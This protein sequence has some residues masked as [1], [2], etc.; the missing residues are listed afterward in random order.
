[1]KSSLLIALIV[2]LGAAYAWSTE[3]ATVNGRPVTDKDMVTALSNLN[4]GQR[5]NV[6]RDMASKR[7]VLSSVIDQEV[8]AQEGEKEKLDQDQEFK[9]AQAAFRKQYLANRVLQRNVGGQF[10]DKAAKAYYEGHKSNFST[11]QVHA[12]HILVSDEKQ[13]QDLLAKAK[14]AAKTK[15]A[16][17]ATAT[18]QTLAEKFSKDP[19]AKNNRGDLGFFGRDRMVSEFTEAAFSAANGDVVGPV[20]TA[21]GYHI[22]RVLE[23]HL[24]K[25]L[26]Y[27]EV[28][29]R[30]KNELRSQLI[31]NY[32]GNLKK[33]AKIQ[34]EEKNL[35]K[36]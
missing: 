24:G 2:C 9:E 27:D 21:F 23:K 3:L 20:K 7:Q 17:E 13:A 35:N 33:T 34:I 29:L 1:M 18:F 19:T 22:I 14:D 15:S 36:L 4:E 5:A 31:Q 6:L 12:L 8:L 26:G 32:V 25:P 30:V 28:E 11:D 16:E 10:T